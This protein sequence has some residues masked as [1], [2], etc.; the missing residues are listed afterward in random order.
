MYHHGICTLM[1][2]EVAGMTEEATR[3]GGPREARKGRRTDPSR[4]AEGTP[5]PGGH[6]RLAAHSGTNGID[7][8]ISVTDLANHVAACRQE[9]GLC[10]G[11]AGRP[12]RRLSSTSSLATPR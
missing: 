10:D 8:D 5:S 12:L 3:Q 11:A 2:A 6:R 7:A 9:P 1:L 4:T